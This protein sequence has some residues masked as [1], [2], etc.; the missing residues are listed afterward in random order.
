[1]KHGRTQQELQ[2]AED[3]LESAR[4]ELANLVDPAIKVLKDM[5]EDDNVPDA[6]R[7]KVATEILDRTGLKTADRLDVSVQKEEIHWNVIL[8][9]LEGNKKTEEIEGKF[10]EV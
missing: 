2:T 6:I 1:M 10:E 5:V 3:R 4:Q 8:A 9:K 7:L